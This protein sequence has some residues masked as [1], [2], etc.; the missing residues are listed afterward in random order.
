MTQAAKI[1]QNYL[2]KRITDIK[3]KQAD[4]ALRR[5]LANY[6][7]YQVAELIR[8]ARKLDK[9]SAEVLYATLRRI[10]YERPFETLKKASNLL[11]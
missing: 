9:N 1:I 5:T 3:K 8:L 2:Q 10:Y 6:F 4:E 7:K 11:P